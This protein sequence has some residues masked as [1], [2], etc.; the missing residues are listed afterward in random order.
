MGK[1]TDAFKKPEPKPEP[2][3]ELHEM[4]R[5]V[6]REVPGKGWVTVKQLFSAQLLGEEIIFGPKSRE[7]AADE[8]AQK[9]QDDLDARREEEMW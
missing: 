3:P 5:Y 4:T 7:F 9:T 8:V 6:L 2:V 1:L